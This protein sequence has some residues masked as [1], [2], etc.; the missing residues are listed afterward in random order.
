[1]EVLDFLQQLENKTGKCLYRH[2]NYFYKMNKKGK[3][4]KTPIDDYNNWDN[5]KID[6]NRGSWSHDK[7]NSYS[8]YIKYVPKLFC[9][10]F[11]TKELG[12]NPLYKLL[13]DKNCWRT[14]TKQG[15]HF[16]VYINDVPLYDN[17]VRVGKDCDI[18]LIYTKRNT[19]ELPN[20]KIF[21]EEYTF[22]W[23]EVSTNFDIIKMNLKS[24][25]TTPTISPATSE[26]DI[27]AKDE[28]LNVIDEPFE[29]LP[30][31]NKNELIKICYDITTKY[32]YDDWIKVGLALYNITAGHQDGLDVWDLWSKKDNMNYCKENLIVKWNN[33]MAS[34]D[35]DKLLGIGSLKRW[36][37][38]DNPKNLFYKE[39]YRN[40]KLIFNEG[41][42]VEVE[43]KANVDGVVD[44]FNKTLLFIKETGEFVITD[45][46]GN[47][48]D[49][50]Y[51]KSLQKVKEHYEKYT[52]MDYFAKTPKMMNP[53]N[54]W[55]TSIKRRE[56]RAI[57]F[58]PRTL[59]DPDI[60]N[61][62]R[63][64]K[65]SPEIA[66]EYNVDDCKAILDHILRIW[67]RGN[68]D[69]Y[70]YVLSWFAHILQKPH[71]KIGVVLCLKSKQGA[72]KGIVVEKLEQIIGDN[73]YV[74]NS[75]A[76][77]LFGDFNGMLEAK[78]LIDLDECFWGG[79]KKLESIVKNKITEKKQPINKKNKELYIIEDYSNYL[80]TT[81]NDWFAG[82]SEED[83]RHYCIQLDN[84]LSGRMT[85][86]KYEKLKPVI[87]S[88]SGSFAKFL[89]NRD[90]SLFNPRVYTKSDLLQDQVQR[91]WNSVKIWFHECLKDGGFV[92]DKNHFI[93]WNCLD[94]D[95]EGSKH[96]GVHFYNKKTKK[97][98]TA[99]HKEWFYNLYQKHYTGG[100][101]MHHDAFFRELQQNCLCNLYKEIRPHQNNCETRNRFIILPDVHTTRNGWNNVQDY[102]YK[103]DEECE[104]YDF[105]MC[106]IDDKD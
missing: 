49:T 76:N 43:G 26:A 36:A 3:R 93:R 105:D 44:F 100:H 39:Y 66:E 53:F 8:F 57:G 35:S 45:I 32:S 77:F 59:D 9:V 87:D 62:W 40:A 14:E 15:H 81:N 11:D 94:K 37:E 85:A 104:E 92:N 90:I 6:N 75:N 80:I 47:G 27:S 64:F 99:Y 2:I 48:E 106:M 31:Y 12:H 73:H 28:I 34:P 86:E 58:N 60:F 51:L 42:D 56:V 71:K 13:L 67:C 52:F 68:E 18:D 55:K 102:D 29:I 25:P 38:Q 101:K 89:Y 4:I 16:Y 50:W 1:M 88:P 7:I 72:G 74:Q 69:E 65:I 10:D 82:V 33:Y 19:W 83:R 5:T 21:G 97:Y 46:K 95:Y 91:N 30:E 20:R 103:W 23:N 41:V 96:G 24:P 79:D 54:L 84:E 17:E 63:G 98:D 61:L 78:I 70:N 22:D